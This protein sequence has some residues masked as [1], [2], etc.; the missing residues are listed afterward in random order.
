MYIS[1]AILHPNLYAFM[2]RKKQLRL[3]YIDE[4][5][6]TELSEILYVFIELNRHYQRA[7]VAFLLHPNPPN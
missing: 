3:R 6:K 1:K 7:T 2:H 5:W 4:Y